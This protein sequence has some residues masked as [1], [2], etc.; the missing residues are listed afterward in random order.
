MR[1]PVLIDDREIKVNILKSK[2]PDFVAEIDEKR[3]DVAINSLSPGILMLSVSG[4]E[5]T[6]WISSCGV[7]KY[8]VSYN[9]HQYEMQ[10]NDQLSDEMEYHLSEGM[11]MMDSNVLT[12]PMP[13]KVIK[14]NAK[15][16]AGVKKGNVVLVIEAMKMENNIIAH[17]NARINK[18]PVSVGQ[19]VEAGVPLV[20]FDE[21]KE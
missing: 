6:T 12:S 17:R 10:R 1:I 9:G 16:G 13:G 14:I 3:Y 11:E 5:Y 2:Y 19:M 4:N 21:D 8:C 20:Y 15:K 18:I 7:L